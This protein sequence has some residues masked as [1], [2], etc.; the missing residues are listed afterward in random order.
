VTSFDK[1]VKAFRSDIMDG[2][3]SDVEKN[4]ATNDMVLEWQAGVKKKI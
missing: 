1:Q 3:K 4:Y 2:M